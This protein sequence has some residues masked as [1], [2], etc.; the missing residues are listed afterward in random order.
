MTKILPRVCVCVCVC[1][2]ERERERER[3]IE[4]TVWM[5]WTNKNVETDIWIE[6]KGYNKIYCICRVIVS[7]KI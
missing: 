1:V 2:R 3:E 5:K 4:R 7:I 6:Q